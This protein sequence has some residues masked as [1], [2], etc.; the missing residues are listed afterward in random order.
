M[1][2][3]TLMKKLVNEILDTIEDVVTA[4]IAILLFVFA[5]GAWYGA[6]Y[7]GQQAFWYPAYLFVAVLF[8]KL[9]KDIIE[10]SMKRKG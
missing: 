1:H 2:E 9:F 10:K 5:A 8:L 3:P 6:T 4:I 7:A